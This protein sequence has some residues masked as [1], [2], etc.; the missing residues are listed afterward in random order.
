M[1]RGAPVSVVGG[2]AWGTALSIHLARLGHPVGL[3]MREA[4]LVARMLER[5]DNPQYLPGVRIPEEVTP[6]AEL[7]PLLRRAEIVVAAVPSHHARSVYR[8]MRASMGDRVPVIVA[9]KGIE[10][11]S[12]ALPA[13]VA[14]QEL[15]AGRPVAVLSGPSFAAE[16]ARGVPTAVVV[17]SANG[18]LAVRIR[19]LFSSGNLRLYAN[20][21]VLGVQLAG[22]LKNVIAVAAGVLDGLGEGRNTLAALVTRGLAE[23]R[24]LGLALGADPA[25]FAGLAGLGDLVLTCTG[26]LSRNR[27]VGR[28]IGRG[29]RLEDVLG[30]SS[31][32]AEGVRTAR[33]AREMGRRACVAMPIVDEVH[34]LLFEDA[35]P[36][37]AVARLMSRPLT[38]EDGGEPEPGR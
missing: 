13:E 35:S 31:F 10:E 23:M 14:A 12:L 37:E 1:N 27:G 9:T 20:R 32:V 18:D 36:K 24:R 16:V 25:T 21:D 29:E 38:S 19:D 6:T 7:G 30:R 22:A 11:G 17:A 8:G 34:A 15:G 3:W 26:D 33:A 2:G 28:A 4:D 5:R